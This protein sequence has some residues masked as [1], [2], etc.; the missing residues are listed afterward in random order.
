MN[1]L[2]CDMPTQKPMLNEK[3]FEVIAKLLRSKAPSKTAARMVLV[4][5]K[6]IKD[7]VD[8]TGVFHTSVIKSV[9]RYRAAHMLIIEGYGLTM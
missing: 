1:V 5:G 3:Q 6:R 9:A 8:V 4:E 7:A 2:D